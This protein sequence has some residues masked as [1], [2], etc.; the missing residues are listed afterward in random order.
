[1]GP[2]E[3][4]GALGSGGMGVVHRARDARLDREVAIK[5][6]PEA[7]QAAPEK[8]RRFEQEARAA[9]ALNHPNLLV[10]YDVGTHEGTPY[11]VTELLEGATLRERLREGKLPFDKAVGYA[12]QIAAGLA[13]AHERGI[14]HRDLKPENVFLTRDGRAKILDFG[15]AKALDEGAAR[16]EGTLTESGAVLGTAGYMA[17]EQVRAQ[18]TDHRADIFGFGAVLYEM[19]SGEPAFRGDSPVERGYAVLTADPPDLARSTILPSREATRIVR[20]CLEKSPDDRFQSARDLCFA[21]EGLGTASGASGRSSTLPPPRRRGSWLAVGALELAAV[22]AGSFLAGGFAAAPASPPPAAVAV[23]PAPAFTRVTFGR[24]WIRNARFAPDGVTVLYDLLDPTA[25]AAPPQIFATI[26]GSPE[27]R[28]VSAPR[29]TLLAV[30]KNGE[31]AL[32]RM[33]ADRRTTKGATLARATLSGGAPRDLLEDVREADWSP[34]GASLLVIRAEAERERIEY[35]VGKVIYEGDAW[36]SHAR[37]SPDG[38][39]VAYLSHPV[40]NDDRGTLDVLLADG[41]HRTLA[42]PYTTVWGLAWAPGGEIWITASKSSPARSVYAVDLAG[43]E[44]LVYQAPASLTIHDIAPS[45]RVL[46]TRDDPRDR[47]FGRVPGREGEVDLSWFD[48]A[49]PVDLSSDCKRLLFFE[50]REAATTEYQSYVR[51]TDGSPAVKLGQ[52]LARALSPDQKWAL[53]SPREPFNTLTLVPTGAGEH[54]ALPAGSLTT[55]DG[56][57]FFPSGDRILIRGRES[58]RGARLWV[59]DLAG[60]DPAPIT[61]EGTA[62]GARISPDGRRIVVLTADSRAALVTAEGGEE[63]PLTGVTEGDVPLQ[64]AENGR[65]IY[66]G[67]R[68]PPSVLAGLSVSVY[69]LDVATGRVDPWRELMPADPTG[70]VRRGPL[71]VTP[72]GKSYVYSYLR[73]LGDAYVADGLG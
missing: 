30:S 55:I 62:L 1:V 32:G 19:L 38:K 6:L 11:P 18:R 39:A 70:V 14:V 63:K 16:A 4:L 7:A 35:P 25:D 71:F 65:A 15:L 61:R 56:A 59:Q 73:V 47:V 57:A 5:S 23:A 22:A 28:L 27:A 3:I 34:D 68:S 33:P 24:G 40:D 12:R 26:P 60:G 67:R 42:G 44:R 52:G 66:F 45:G 46:L 49:N 13:A 72:D 31:L 2:Y 36:P 53:I 69:K 8:L 50:G 43:H 10:V 54:R 9:G 58:G 51:A 20:R 64:W 21:L 17:P 41:A 48:G 37:I 29:T